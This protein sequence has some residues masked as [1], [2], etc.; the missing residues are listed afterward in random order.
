MFGMWYS[1]TKVEL[2][3]ERILGKAV[4]FKVDLLLKINT[5]KQAMPTIYQWAI[6]KRQLNKRNLGDS[7]TISN[8]IV[9]N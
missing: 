6:A 5:R 7:K 4:I 3:D 2:N 9:N 8:S 1:V